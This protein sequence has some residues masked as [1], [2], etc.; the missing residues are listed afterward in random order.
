M[1]DQVMRIPEQAVQRQVKPEQKGQLLQA[2]SSIGQVL[3]ATPALASHVNIMRGGGTPLDSATRAFMEPRLGHDF[4]SVRIHTNEAANESAKALGARAYT[5]GSDIAFRNGA[6][7]SGS[8]AGRRLLAHE[9]THVMQQSAGRASDAGPPRIQRAITDL[10]IRGDQNQSSVLHEND[11]LQWVD[12]LE[13][14][15]K[16]IGAG[17]N[18]GYHGGFAKAFGRESALGL[19]K[20]ESIAR[21]TQADGQKSADLVKW[22][23]LIRNVLAQ[24]TDPT[25]NTLTEVNV[26]DSMP[27]G[28]S[29][30]WF[31]GGDLSIAFDAMRWGGVRDGG[32]TYR[33][34][35]DWD[36][37][38]EH[39]GTKWT[40]GYHV[41]F[42]VPDR[43]PEQGKGN[44]SIIN[45]PKDLSPTAADLKHPGDGLVSVRL[46]STQQDAPFQ[47]ILNIP[48][49]EMPLDWAFV[50]VNAKP[51]FVKYIEID[52]SD[53]GI[54]FNQ[55][56]IVPR[57]YL[58]KKTC[59]GPVKGLDVL[60]AIE[61][62]NF[63]DMPMKQLEEIGRVI[64]KPE[65]DLGQGIGCTEELAIDVNEGLGAADRW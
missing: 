41:D 15:Y 4:S 21:Y 49:S 37:E 14:H 58:S 25:G 64:D 53:E 29:G 1:A 60:S 12:A 27:D 55:I 38:A 19:W 50:S 17:G 54:G 20:V 5:M 11:F 47:I 33:T 16:F 9:L 43:A 59:I 63:D 32:L 6:W 7:D 18:L 26:A 35:A 44:F 48:A 42:E 65:V 2:K 10:E 57:V 8:L 61:K 39:D 28:P 34:S 30:Q 46:T 31:G 56:P 45:P 22:K 52:I 62:R 23:Y 51:R 40:A 3:D 24:T 36:V 13:D